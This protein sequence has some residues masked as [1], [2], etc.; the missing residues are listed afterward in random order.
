MSQIMWLQRYFST[1][2]T[3][4]LTLVLPAADYIFIRMQKNTNF[5][6]HSWF[7]NVACINMNKVH[8]IRYSIYDTLSG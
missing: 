5:E 1:S 3:P 4:N 8:L 6:K 7:W 2:F